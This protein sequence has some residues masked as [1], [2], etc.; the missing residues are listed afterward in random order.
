[1]GGDSPQTLESIGKQWDVTRERI[2]QVE[3]K[4]LG[5]LRASNSWKEAADIDLVKSRD[6]IWRGIARSRPWLSAPVGPDIF[7]KI[8]GRLQLFIDVLY[9]GF[10]DYLRA[11][12]PFAHHGYMNDVYGDVPDGVA[13]ERITAA[14]D[15]LKMPCLLSMAAERAGVEDADIVIWAD[16]R[17]KYI[18]YLDFLIGSAGKRRQGRTVRLYRLIKHRWKSSAVSLIRIHDEYLRMF[19]DDQCSDRDIQISFE[20]S[21][22]LFLNCYAKGWRAIGADD[23]QDYFGVDSLA[24]DVANDPVSEDLELQEYEGAKNRI[25]ALLAEAGPL[26]LGELR[27]R[28]KGDADG[29]RKIPPGS[30]GPTLIVYNDFIRLAP[31]IYGLQS[32]LDAI[33]SGRASLPRAMFDEWQVVLYAAWKWGGDLSV[34]FPLWSPKN[35][36]AWAKWAQEKLGPNTFSSLLWSCNPRYWPVDEVQRDKWVTLKGEQGRY[37][38]AQSTAGDLTLANTTVD[39]ILAIALHAREA[40]G[41]SW[42]TANMVAGKRPDDVHIAASLAYLAAV[43][44]LTAPSHWQQRHRSADGLN[45]IIDELIQIRGHDDD[46]AAQSDWLNSLLLRLYPSKDLGWIKKWQV[47]SMIAKA[48]ES[49]VVVADLRSGDWKLPVGL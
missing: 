40:E 11:T 7:K 3:K 46:S 44:G 42:I 35:E 13:L 47:Q 27:E 6:D 14:V 29:F 30:I 32:H 37:M 19:P 18:Q 34:K 10:N 5:K 48:T 31:G 4:A 20:M 25:R 33:E 41:V 43:G 16:M 2:R 22:V 26:S 21:D 24:I 12:F 28:L 38:L 15:S 45:N 17:G 9:D 8:E 1:M 23:Q 49:A 39:R 36:A